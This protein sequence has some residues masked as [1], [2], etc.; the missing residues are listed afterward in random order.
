MSQSQER[1][2]NQGDDNTTQRAA[3]ELPTDLKAFEARLAALAPRDDRLDREQLMFLAGRA[4]VEGS[5]EIS[6]LRARQPREKSW[7]VAFAAMTAIAATLLVMLVARPVVTEPPVVQVAN[8]V[9]RPLAARPFIAEATDSNT[10]VLSTGDARRHDI[11]Q[12]LS[13]INLA[14]NGDAASPSAAEGDGATLT[15]AAWRQVLQGAEATRPPTTDSS[16]MEMRMNQG[17]KV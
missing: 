1:P 16:D 7:P 6:G 3:W 15:P 13:V 9:K 2:I 12:L 10:N 11:E 4:S 14:G 5:F 17:L 8:S